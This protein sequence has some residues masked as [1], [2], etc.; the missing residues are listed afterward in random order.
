MDQWSLVNERY[1][2]VQGVAQLVYS[3]TCGTNWVNVHGFVTGNR[4]EVGLT[5]LSNGAS[6]GATVVNV[7][8]AGTPQTIAP[9]NTCVLVS[10]SIE[11]L[12]TGV[13]EGYRSRVYC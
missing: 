10:S 12:A 7:G 9:G 11:D 6:Y 13:L 8:S 2:E 5:N 4:Y 1:G 3:P